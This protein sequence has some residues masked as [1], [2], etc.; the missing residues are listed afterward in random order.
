[1]ARLA[2]I[3]VSGISIA[4]LETCIDLPE[5]KLCFDLGRAQYFA[6]ARP[7]VLFTHQ[8]FGVPSLRRDALFQPLQRRDHAWIL[9][10]KPLDQL[11]RE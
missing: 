1:M 4:G 11:H 8:V 6:L 2:G 5:W 3:E 10:T 7:L 9:V